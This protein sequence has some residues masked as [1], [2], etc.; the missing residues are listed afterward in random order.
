MVLITSF[1][2]CSPSRN[3]VPF[4]ATAAEAEELEGSEQASPEVTESPVSAAATGI[5]PGSVVTRGPDW[6]WGAQDGYDGGKGRVLAVDEPLKGWVQVYWQSTGRVF[7]YRMGAHGRFDL[8]EVRRGGAEHPDA[9]VE[10][11]TGAESTTPSTDD[12]EVEF[13]DRSP[14]PSPRPSVRPAVRPT[15]ADDDVEWITTTEA[16]VPGAVSN[17]G[18]SP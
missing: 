18:K 9:D 12:N 8:R 2:H 10:W 15:V 13:P 3:V 6:V 5:M 14:T 1:A 7:N 4:A 16:A 11:I 17:E